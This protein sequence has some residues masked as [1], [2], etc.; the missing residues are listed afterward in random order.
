MKKNNKVD[1]DLSQYGCDAKSIKRLLKKLQ[2]RPLDN[3][4]ST[5]Y[6]TSNED[7]QMN[8]SDATKIFNEMK[9]RPHS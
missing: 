6:V 3:R 9:Q 1:I 2:K 7:I 5:G 4:P 8:S